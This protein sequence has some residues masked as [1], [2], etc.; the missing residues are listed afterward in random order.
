MRSKGTGKELEARRLWAIDLL[1]Q[2]Y[3]GCEV[4]R[5][6]GVTP[7]AVSQWK[8]QWEQGGRAALSAQPN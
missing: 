8:S 3:K 1:Q 4:A 6:L 5:A 7:G 2:G